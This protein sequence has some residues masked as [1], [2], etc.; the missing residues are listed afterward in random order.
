LHEG[1][2][3]VVEGVREELLAGIVAG[4]EPRDLEEAGDG[5]YAAAGRLEVATSSGVKDEDAEDGDLGAGP[6][7]VVPRA[8]AS[9]SADDR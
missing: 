3:P 6:R 1:F 4:D 5:F 7:E 8:R 2:G 9:F